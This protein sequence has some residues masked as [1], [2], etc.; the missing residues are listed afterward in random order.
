MPSPDEPSEVTF[1]STDGKGRGVLFLPAGQPSPAPEVI[2]LHGDFGL[3]DAIRRYAR[4]LADRGYLA[5]AVDLYRGEKITSLM[6]AHEVD[7]GLPEEGTVF[8][9]PD[10]SK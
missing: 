10:P 3:N 2:V 1:A 8:T 7:R 4:R 5:L 6:H 9:I